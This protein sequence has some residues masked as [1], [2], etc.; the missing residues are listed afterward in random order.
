MQKINPSLIRSGSRVEDAMDIFKAAIEVNQLS[1]HTIQNW[2]RIYLPYLTDPEGWLGVWMLKSDE[3]SSMLLKCRLWD[4]L[5]VKDPNCVQTIRPVNRDEVE[6]EGP[7][8]E[9]YDSFPLA[10]DI[11][12]PIAMRFFIA[13]MAFQES[14]IVLENEVNIKPVTGFYD[15]TKELEPGDILPF[16]DPVRLG[17]HHLNK[18]ICA[19]NKDNTLAKAMQEDLKL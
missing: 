10:S 12:V 7:G 8:A 14:L 1:R 19:I 16:Q 9:T 17:A 11:G 6:D 4:A 3:L 2:G 5:Y 13:K 15:L 18:Y